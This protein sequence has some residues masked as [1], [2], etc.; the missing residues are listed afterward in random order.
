MKSIFHEGHLGIEN[1]KKR[2][3][4]ALFW[5]LISKG[6][7]DMISKCPTCLTYRNRQPNET[8][9]KH[10]ISDDPWT[11]CAAEL[12]RLQGHYYLLIVDY[13]SKFMAVENL[14]NPQSETAIKFS[15]NLAYPKS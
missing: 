2:A 8:P 6:L 15:H 1:C 3:R 7:E 14:Q 11:K 5:T 9:I 12:F 4:Q 10:E 13:Y